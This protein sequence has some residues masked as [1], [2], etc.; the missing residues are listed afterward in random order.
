MRLIIILPIAHHF[1]GRQLCRRRVAGSGAAPGAK[2]PFSLGTA[3][4]GAAPRWGKRGNYNP[5]ATCLRSPTAMDQSLRAALE[6]TGLPLLPVLLFRGMR[7]AL[8]AALRRPG[9][10]GE[11][12]RYSQH[13][14]EVIIADLVRR[15]GTSSR[16]CVDI[17][18]SDGVRLSN[19]RRL[20][21]EGW[22]G[23]AIE[24]EPTRFAGLSL[25]Y[26]RLREVALVRC[27][28]TPA[29]VTALLAAFDTPPSFGV[30][31]LDIDSYDYDVL[32]AI[33]GRYRPAVVCSEFNEKMPP[34]VHFAVR[35]RPGA[36]Y[37][38]GAF[39][40]CSLSALVSL[41]AKYDY[42]L[43]GVEYCNAFFVPREFGLTA[44]SAEEAYR[45][46]YVERAERRTLF[47]YND[48][49][50]LEMA[51]A[52]LVQYFEREFAPYADRFE[53]RPR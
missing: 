21:E 24:V 1:F 51:P 49:R 15:T 50:W 3:E 30:L 19:C 14:E 47:W 29:N 6:M 45:A 28:V 36:V 16:F 44:V 39:Y 52:E 11:R 18:A 27:A 41:A 9:R 22:R 20:F 38:R 53:C 13:D 12:P 32:E 4:R 35:W 33:W 37:P 40:G 46:G 26:H 34:P 17:G 7:H 23:V 48:E 8:R 25:A 2:G 43:T 10:A 31:S 5:A 42:V